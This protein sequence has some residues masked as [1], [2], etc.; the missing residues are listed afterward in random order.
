[1]PEVSLERYVPEEDPFAAPLTLEG[2]ISGMLGVERG[3]DIESARVGEGQ[4]DFEQPGAA[5]NLQREPVQTVKADPQGLHVDSDTDSSAR[6]DLTV[7]DLDAD[8]ES[9]R[10]DGAQVVEADRSSVAIADLGHERDLV[11]SGY[12]LRPRFGAP[13]HLEARLTDLGHAEQGGRMAED[14]REQ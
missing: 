14:D 7:L 9:G 13:K 12:S 5:S 10:H 11:S 1:M 8:I 6:R 3:K 4:W 2:A